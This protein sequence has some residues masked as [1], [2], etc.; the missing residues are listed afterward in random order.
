[1]LKQAEANLQRLELGGGTVQL[2]RL[3][4][5]TIPPIDSGYADAQLDDHRHLSRDDFPWRPPLVM[6]VQARTNLEK[7]RGTLGFGFWN[8]PF[9]FSLGQAGAARKLPATPNVLWFFY[10]SEPNELAMD[11]ELPP[12]GWKASSW[13][14]AHLPPFLLALPAI[15][16][17]ALSQLPLV[18]KW[19][20]RAAKSAV[21]ASEAALP[22]KLTEWHSYRLEWRHDS[23]DFWVDDRMVLRAPAPP[24]GPLGF[25]A[26][27]DNQ[28]AV[29]S[30]ERGI[31]F[32]VIS[33]EQPQKLELRELEIEPLR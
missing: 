1:M 23:A 10:G 32:G 26:W 27:I 18:R 21:T 24:T 15:S 33:T 8:D 14:T 3:I 12:T 25:V 13:R 7:P 29:L 28:Y 2:G 20:V 30:T 9:S 22:I 17:L 4:E 5:L 16:A 19:V 6:S 11:P 31:R